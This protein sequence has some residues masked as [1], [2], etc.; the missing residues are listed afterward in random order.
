MAKEYA[1]TIEQGVS[2]GWLKGCY[3][4]LS[5]GAGY[6]QLSIYIGCHHEPEDTSPVET[7]E[8]PEHL[9]AA[10]RVADFILEKASD[11]KKYR[12]MPSGRSLPGVVLTQ[13]GSVVQVN[14]LDNPG[15]LACFRAFIEDILPEIAPLTT[16]RACVFCGEETG[17]AS[18]PIQLNSG[19]VVPIHNACA[20]TLIASC[21]QKQVEKPR[22]FPG[23]PILGA[24]VGALLGAAVWAGV[25]IAGYM[26]SLVGLLIAFLTFKGYT[27]LGGRPGKGMLVTLILCV[28]LAVAIG[29]TTALVY[30]MH[31]IY[32]E[33]VAE[34]S[35]GQSAIPEEQFIRIVLPELWADD[36]ARGE[37]L[38]NLG[39]GL[40][41]A[42]LGSFATLYSA[43]RKPEKEREPKR[44]QGEL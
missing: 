34:L 23:L 25:S 44:L 35:A 24:L 26:S 19:D 37:I 2:Y 13:G 7:N 4:T 31:T 5:E 36:E 40:F 12:L 6:K 10:D 33:A 20:D 42:A 14:F 30:E 38:K 22:V 11:A 32:Q 17:A 21:Q 39:V 15:T 3:V 16:P 8:M 28:V 18:Q 43:S 41:F 1:L 29:N 27:L 9:K